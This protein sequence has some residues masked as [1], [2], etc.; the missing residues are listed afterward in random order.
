MDTPENM[1][2]RKG[3]LPQ[4]RALAKTRANFMLVLGL[5]VCMLPTSHGLLAAPGQHGGRGRA[6]A[7][8]S[9]DASHEDHAG[10]SRSRSRTPPRGLRPQEDHP[11][12]ARQQVQALVIGEHHDMPLADPL[13]WML[14][15]LAEEKQ[16][17]LFEGGTLVAEDDPDGEL[18]SFQMETASFSIVALGGRP[19]GPWDP[20]IPSALAEAARRSSVLERFLQGLRDGKTNAEKKDLLQLANQAMLRK[21]K[22]LPG[23]N[24]NDNEGGQQHGVLSGGSA[25]SGEDP[26]SRWTFVSGSGFTN[27]DEPGSGFT[28]NDVQLLMEELRFSVG[29]VPSVVHPG[30]DV[31]DSGRPKSTQ[32]KPR[33]DADIYLLSQGRRTFRELIDGF[34]SEMNLH[35][36]RASPLN[37]EQHGLE[38]FVGILN[39]CLGLEQRGLLESDPAERERQLAQ[40]VSE[41]LAEG[42]DLMECLSKDLKEVPGRV[43]L[44]MAGLQAIRE[45][46]AEEVCEKYFSDQKTDGRGG[47]RS[48]SASAAGTSSR[49]NSWPQNWPA[50]DRLSEG[51]QLQI[52][53]LCRKGIYKEELTLGKDDSNRGG[54]GLFT[55]TRNLVWILRVLD[56]WAKQGELHQVERRG[57]WSRFLSTGR[58]SSHAKLVLPKVFVM[59]KTHVSHFKRRLQEARPDLQIQ[60]AELSSERVCLSDMSDV[61][62]EFI[63]SIYL[64]SGPFYKQWSELGRELDSSQKGL[65]TE[66]LDEIRENIRTQQEDEDES[67]DKFEH[68]ESRHESVVASSLK[69]KFLEFVRETKTSASA[70]DELEGVLNWSRWEY[71]KDGRLVHWSNAEGLIAVLR[72]LATNVKTKNPGCSN[73]AVM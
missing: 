41:R 71:V 68:E 5:L 56:K 3:V 7:S 22:N 28:E 60:V 20:K 2:F 53:L 58:R 38:D 32:L 8:L 61:S 44:L 9:S 52:R 55:K 4:D 16:I 11:A 46:L 48:A 17:E 73:C 39:R 12:A 19:D 47:S 13:R 59:G 6:L 49:Y 65:A 40:L 43:A 62:N 10:R 31:A 24:D 34:I 45:K 1:P 54:K 26:S 29:V 66:L 63:R 30:E 21:I 14:R 51:E 42:P 50:Q 27:M 33:S 36:S 64:T 69:S 18:H 72:F 23:G 70:E 25:S 57:A 15:K 37:R 35:T 67:D